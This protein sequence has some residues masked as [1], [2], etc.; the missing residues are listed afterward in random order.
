MGLQ[1]TID[2]E[3]LG[4]ISPKAIIV[5]LINNGWRFSFNGH[6]T[7]LLSSDV[8]NYDWQDMDATE[9]NIREFL[10]SH[11][12]KDKIGIVLVND[13]VGGNFLIHPGW[14]SFSLSVNRLYLPF[15]N[16]IVDFNWYLNKLHVFLNTIKI[17]A[18]K[19]ELIY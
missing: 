3:F 11:G 17:S 14:M 13:N 6:V 4:D 10:G 18:I 15:G 1:A 19:C 8:D 7:F 16:K 5:G 2:V 12:E 9:F